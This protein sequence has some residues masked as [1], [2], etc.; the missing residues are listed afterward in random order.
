MLIEGQSL[1]TCEIEP[2]GSAIML[3]LIDDRGEAR[4]L[5]LPV[6]QVGALAM[7]LPSLIERALKTRYRD[8]SLRY[9]YELG[10]WTLEQA[11]DPQ[12]RM[13][14]LRTTDGFSVCFTLPLAQGEALSEAL[15]R[16][17]QRDEPVRA[18]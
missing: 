5:R 17:H 10:S 6:E 8:S 12:T 1:T 2:D 14:T 13:M 11:S 16:S 3:G 9:A 15:A 18:N 7:T 4:K